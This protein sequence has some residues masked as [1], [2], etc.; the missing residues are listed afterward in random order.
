MKTYTTLVI[1]YMRV[2][3]GEWVNAAEVGEYLM[4]QDPRVGSRDYARQKAYNKLV[5]LEKCGDVERKRMENWQKGSL[6]FW[7]LVT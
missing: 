7:R 5:L 3:P 1:E 4:L 6:V 2:H